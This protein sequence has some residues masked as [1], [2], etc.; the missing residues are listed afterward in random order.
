MISV[1]IPVYNCE[2]YIERCVESI[3]VQKSANVDLEIVLVDDGS[4]DNSYNVCVEMKKRYP[5]SVVLVHKDNGGVSSARNAGMDAAHG[6]YYFFAD[7]DDVVTEKALESLTTLTSKE[8]QLYMGEVRICGTKRQILYTKKA[9]YTKEEFIYEMMTEPSTELLASGVWGKLFLASII[10]KNKIRFDE[11]YQNGEDGLFFADYLKY[12]SRV[13]VFDGE[14]PVYKLYRYD[15]GE[16]ESAVSYF[17]PDLFEFFVLHRE[18][19]YRMLYDSK[20]IN[21]KEVHQHYINDLIILLVRAFAFP[22]F[23]NE[24]VLLE[25]LKKLLRNEML[26]RASRDYERKLRGSSILIPFGLR[27]NCKYILYWQLR[28]RGK[29]YRKR[30]YSGEK[31]RSIFR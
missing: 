12:V 8:A 26:K 1:I 15:A 31:L 14:F 17:Y 7:S 6:E 24:K 30:R 27:H 10:T 9:S 22:E 25:I 19:L 13:E 23:F 11:R 3:I 18:M 4:K 29:Q 20:G 28:R 21:L 5:D 16:R 2:K